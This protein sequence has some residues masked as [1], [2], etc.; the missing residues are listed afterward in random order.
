MDELIENLEGLR[1]ELFEFTGNKEID[2]K[3]LSCI[4][5]AKNGTHGAKSNGDELAWLRG[6]VEAYEKAL[7]AIGRKI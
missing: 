4:D 7:S 6:K 1:N 3:M 2:A 5:L